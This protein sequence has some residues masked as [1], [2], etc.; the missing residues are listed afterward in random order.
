MFYTLFPLSLLQMS[1]FRLHLKSCTCSSLGKRLKCFKA[2]QEFSKQLLSR[3]QWFH[4]M[5]KHSFDSL[6]FGSNHL[7]DDF[8]SSLESSWPLLNNSTTQRVNSARQIQHHNINY[9]FSF[10]LTHSPFKT[11]KV[12]LTFCRCK[13]F[14]LIKGQGT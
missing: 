9:S 1:I 7:F 3:F 10:I 6:I 4:K 5:H 8:V 12:Y 11:F 13:V 2:A 14:D